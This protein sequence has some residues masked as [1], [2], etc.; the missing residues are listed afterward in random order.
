V[1]IGY[2][3]PE[4]DATLSKLPPDNYKIGWIA[5]FCEVLQ[6]E[7]NLVAKACNYPNLLVLPFSFELIRLSFR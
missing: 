5:G 6:A 2:P 3:V 1:D 7:A 4:L